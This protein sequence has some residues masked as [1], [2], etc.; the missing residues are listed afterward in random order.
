MDPFKNSSPCPSRDSREPPAGGALSLSLF[1][2]EPR[3]DVDQI[4][5][6]TRW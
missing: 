4:A 1:P 6:A 3:K 2:S 5:S